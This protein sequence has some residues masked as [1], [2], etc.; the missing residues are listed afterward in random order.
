MINYTKL[1][2]KVWTAVKHVA[3]LAILDLVE[4]FSVTTWSDN[5]S[6]VSDI[7]YLLLKTYFFF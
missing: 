5:F 7:Q 3:G 4:R 1:M 2:F 6:V